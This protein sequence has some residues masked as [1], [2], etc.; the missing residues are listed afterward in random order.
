MY[1]TS[2]YPPIDA[3]PPSAIVRRI[4]IREIN[5]I[6]VEDYDTHDWSYA[7]W[8]M[9]PEKEIPACCIV[10]GYD[11]EIACPRGRHPCPGLDGVF[12]GYAAK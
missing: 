7:D 8:H 1:Y 11:P 2:S 4:I 10:Y 6:V 5:G 3:P 12:L 9:A